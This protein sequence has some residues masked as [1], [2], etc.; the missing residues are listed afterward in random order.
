MA[1]LS[2][3]QRLACPLTAPLTSQPV[4]QQEVLWTTGSGLITGVGSD[5]G[6]RSDTCA[7]AVEIGGSCGAL[8]L[9]ALLD[10]DSDFLLF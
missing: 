7:A 1:S 10:W 9:S 3:L 8:G 4:G 6:V 2:S 5:H